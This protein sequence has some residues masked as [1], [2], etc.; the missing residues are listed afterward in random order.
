VRKAP[1]LSESDVA[2]DYNIK[3]QASNNYGI[4]SDEKRMRKV[5]NTFV[6]EKILHDSTLKLLLSHQLDHVNSRKLWKFHFLLKLFMNREASSIW[7]DLGSSKEIKKKS[8]NLWELCLVLL[9]PSS[10]KEHE[11]HEKIIQDSREIL[12]I[13][14]DIVPNTFFK[15]DTVL[16]LEEAILTWTC[17]RTAEELLRLGSA[18]T[19]TTKTTTILDIA[20]LVCSSTAP[21]AIV[22]TASKVLCL[23]L[24]ITKDSRQILAFL[25]SDKD[26]TEM[27]CERS[28]RKLENRT[29]CITFRRNV[30]KAKAFAALNKMNGFKLNE[31]S[32]YLRLGLISEPSRYSPELLELLCEVRTKS[33]TYD[34]SMLMNVLRESL[35]SVESRLRRGPRLVEQ[36]KLLRE[37]VRTMHVR[38]MTS[39]DSTEFSDS[40]KALTQYLVSGCLFEPKDRTSWPLCSNAGSEA[41]EQCCAVLSALSNVSQE[42]RLVIASE[43]C[44]HLCPDSES[45]P[46][47]RLPEEEKDDGTTNLKTKTTTTTTITELYN[48]LNNNWI[49]RPREPRMET[50]PLGLYNLMNT[51]FAN[52]VLQQLFTLPEI[53]SIV[54]EQD[55]DEIRS[56]KITAQNKVETASKEL[57]VSTK[58][59]DDEKEIKQAKS[60]LEKL[61]RD[62]Q[63]AAREW[64]VRRQLQWTFAAL[65]GQWCGPAV[66][67]KGLIESCDM[68][69]NHIDM[70]RQNDCVEFFS[71][72]VQLCGLDNMFECTILSVRSQSKKYLKDT[73]YVIKLQV[74]STLE[75]A[76]EEFFEPQKTYL[77]KPPSLLALNLIR[78]VGK[79]QDNTMKFTKNRGRCK[80]PR[81]IDL[82]P[83]LIANFEKQKREEKEEERETCVY[84]LHG[85]IV[86][87]GNAANNGHYYSFA[88]T[89]TSDD[90]QQWWEFN[91]DRVM[92]RDAPGSEEFERNCC[93]GENTSSQ[94]YVLVYARRSSATQSSSCSSSQDFH[95]GFVPNLDRRPSTVVV[96]RAEETDKDTK[97]SLVVKKNEK[98]K[99]AV[100]RMNA[101]LM[102]E[103]V[104]FSSFFFKLLSSLVTVIPAQVSST[105]PY[106]NKRILE[107]ASRTPFRWAVRSSKVH[108]K[109]N[110]KSSDWLP[111][112]SIFQKGDDVEFTCLGFKTSITSSIIDI[113]QWLR[114]LYT[115]DSF[116]PELAKIAITS[117][118]GLVLTNSVKTSRGSLTRLMRNMNDWF[119]QDP[120][121]CVWF[122]SGIMGLADCRD[123]WTLTIEDISQICLRPTGQDSKLS[124][125]EIVAYPIIAAL[126]HARDS[127]I[128]GECSSAIASELTRQLVSSQKRKET[129]D[130]LVR[131][132]TVVSGM[133]KRLDEKDTTASRK[134][135]YDVL[136]ETDE[137]VPGQRVQIHFEKMW[138]HA[139]YKELDLNPR[140]CV[141]V[142]DVD[143]ELDKPTRCPAHLVTSDTDTDLTGMS[144]PHQ[145]VSISM[146]DCWLENGVMPAVAADVL[147]QVASVTLCSKPD[148]STHVMTCLNKMTSLIGTVQMDPSLR[149]WIS[150]L[151]CER[152]VRVLFREHSFPISLSLSLSRCWNA[153]RENFFSLISLFSVPH[154]PTIT[155]LHLTDTHPWTSIQKKS[156]QER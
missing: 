84:E 79:W 56:K 65:Q 107:S 33:S 22:K 12:Q 50:R 18:E 2:D 3:E 29:E 4:C 154:P 138:Y 51:C 144:P 57:Q 83:Y 134:T 64:A 113:N 118:I 132:S 32:K 45:V 11:T 47:D 31:V 19:T 109:Q 81:S 86:H 34:L 69:F 78:F 156:N 85:V 46:I 126:H 124:W 44:I 108:K 23:T 13:I 98:F 27:L 59:M 73:Q 136:E 151:S 80:L 111:L 92:K 91:D 38:T 102:R 70:S 39:K 139:T 15:Q 137:L 75:K 35:F 155:H 43:I 66:I 99:S 129:Q 101:V 17:V 95:G 61:K 122:L 125:S 28:R 42:L 1:L 6:S 104:L 30:L 14:S 5:A 77:E 40:A 127:L 94:A 87:R 97:S 112:Y 76:L 71:S 82:A 20:R 52:S 105:S 96:R 60:K 148:D 72:L 53:R 140:R 145:S 116:V 143:K 133:S 103:S 149:C 115:P 37:Y 146:K 16:S 26:L 24:K 36:L 68:A 62:A 128:E 121:I 100:R 142:C 114:P 106:S 150:K 152:V 8:V 74:R 58:I 49:R 88:R 135:F 63:D 48:W 131:L 55:M 10:N 147:L 93:G 120:K 90:G 119:S 9:S 89:S 67:P 110:D 117:Y 25:C 21:K 141:V 130:F 7:K 54:F 41:I 153:K 123:R